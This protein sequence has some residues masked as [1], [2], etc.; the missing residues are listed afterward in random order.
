MSTLWNR[1]KMSRSSCPSVPES[2]IDPL[3][4]TNVNISEQRQSTS[5]ACNPKRGDS[6]E[7]L[8]GEVYVPK[9]EV[10]PGVLTEAQRLALKF[11]RIIQ[12]C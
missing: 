12:V 7:T 10:Y 4:R 8:K 11:I 3:I 9:A 6:M 2:M 1:L 5:S